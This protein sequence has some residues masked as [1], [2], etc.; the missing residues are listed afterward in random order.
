MLLSAMY[1]TV[2]ADKQLVQHKSQLK[3]RLV[4]L[5]TDFA[6]VAVAYTRPLCSP[7][8]LVCT[9]NV[10]NSKYQCNT[11]ATVLYSEI[12]QVFQRAFIILWEGLQ[13][14]P[15]VPAEQKDMAVLCRSQ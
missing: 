12:E 6:P 7:C 5:H 9:F 1:S 13:W 15:N 14:Q 11:L 8:K 3:T 4:L 10:P 2:L